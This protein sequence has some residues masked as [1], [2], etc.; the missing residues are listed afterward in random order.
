MFDNLV[1]IAFVFFS[2]RPLWAIIYNTKKSLGLGSSAIRLI[3][4]NVWVI[5]KSVRPEA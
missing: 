4:Y 2:T 1:L 5:L 3:N